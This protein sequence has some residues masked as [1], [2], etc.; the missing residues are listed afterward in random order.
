MFQKPAFGANTSFGAST[1]SPFGGFK[2]TTGTSAFGAAPAFGAGATSQPAAGGG[3]FGATNTTGGLFGNTSTTAPTSAFGTN[4]TG[5]FGFGQPSTSGGLFG[6]NTNTGGLFGTNQQN[7]AN[8]FG[9]KPAG[10]GFGGAPAAGTTASGLFGAPAQ[11]TSGLFA[12][13]NTSM[14]GGG[15][16]GGTTSAFGQPQTTGTAL[17]KYN[18]VPGTDVMMKSGAST[19]INI[20]H[21]CITCMKEY[22]NKSLEELRLEDYIA[23]RKG[24]SNTGMFGGF[25]PQTENKSL[26]GGSSFGQPTATSASSMFT[27]G[28]NTFGQSNSFSFGGAAQT[29]ATSTLFGAAKP[30]FGTTSAPGGGLF[31]TSTTQAAPAFGATNAFGFGANTQNQTNLFGAK[32]ATSAF[33]T[34]PASGT[35]GFGAFGANTTGGTLFNAKPA[36]TQATTFGA[37][38]TGFGGL[39][40]FGAATSTTG[41]LFGANN[42]F[43]AKPAAPAFGFGTNTNT[44]GFG[45]AS[46][47]NSFQK[48]TGTLF[49]TTFSTANTSL[50]NPAQNTQPL[51]FGTGT[52]GLGAG[53]LNFGTSSLGGP[54]LGGLGGFGATANTTLNASNLA[55]SAASGNVHE[56]ILTLAARPYGESSLYKDLLPDSTTKTEN[57]L[58]P[59]NPAAVKAVLDSSGYRVGSP[60]TRIRVH[61]RTTDQNDK[62]SLFDGLEESD[63]SLEGK[64]TLKP[65][66]KRLVLRPHNRVNNVDERPLE[67]NRSFEEAV[68]SPQNGIEPV[69]STLASSN[70]AKGLVNSSERPNH[71]SFEDNARGINTDLESSSEKHSSWLGSSR[72]DSPRLY[73]DL[74]KE[75]SNIVSPTERRASWLTTKPLRKPLSVH[76]TDSVENSVRELRA[77]VHSNIDKE[78]DDLSVSEEENIAPVESSPH[79]SGVKLTRPG[80]Y[81]V[82]SLDEMLRYK[83][84]DGSI[85]V[86]Q[87]TIGRKNYGNVTFDGEVNVTGLNLDELVQ[88]LNKEIVVYPDD[89]VKPPFGQGLNLKATV[90]LDRVW[91][92][93]KTEKKY[94]TDPERLSKMDYES[95]LR[96]ACDKHDTKFVEYRPETGS[97]V[98]RVKHFSK[99]G[100]T[101]S[102][103]D[104]EQI[105]NV[106]RQLANQALQKA[107]PIAPALPV[108]Q[109]ASGPGLGGL[110]SLA[111]KDNN[112]MVMQQ[113]S[114][115]LFNGS[116][117]AYDMDVTDDVITEHSTLYPDVSRAFGVKS[118]TGELARLEHR[119][120]RHVQLM[121]ASLYADTEMDD[122]VSVSTGDQRVPS[123]RS[124]IAE[125]VLITPAVMN[126][127]IAEEMPSAV[128]TEEIQLR[129][130]IVRPHTNILRYHRKVPPLRHTIAGRLDASCIA[131]LAVSRARLSRVGF[132]P[133]RDIVYVTTHN[134]ITDLSSTSDLGGLD[135]YVRG[136]HN[137][138][139][140]EHV[141]ARVSLARCDQIGKMHELL[142]NMS[143]ALLDHSTYL[144]GDG[145]NSPQ[146]VVTDDPMRR[147]DLLKL[148]VNGSRLCANKNVGLFTVSGNYCLEIWKL[149]EALWE[150]DLKNNGV[151]GMNERSIVDRHCN[152]ID[153]LTAAVSNHTDKDLATPSQ[154]EDEDPCDLHSQSVWILLL[155]GRILEAC[156]TA[157]ANGDLNM[158]MLIAQAASDESFRALLS[159]QLRLWSESGALTV[160]S[161]HKIYI[162]RLLA[163]ESCPGDGL[164]SVDWLRAFNA[165]ARYLTPQVPTLDRIVSKYESFFCD[166]SSM[167]EEEVDLSFVQNDLETGM[168]YPV[169]DYCVGCNAVVEHKNT[170]RRIL[171]LR[172]ELIRARA[173]NSR[174]KLIPESYTPDPLDYSLSFL[175][176][177]WF[178]N[179]TEQSITG[180]A[181]QLEA[182]GFWDLAVLIVM[183][184][185][186]QNIRNNCIRKILSRNVPAQV[187]TAVENEQMKLLD[188]L[189]IPKHWILL[190]QAHRA[191]YEKLPAVEVE[192]LVGAG[193]WNAAHRVLVNELMP[194]A[195][196]S[197]KFDGLVNILERMNDA[198][199]RNEVS[200]WDKGGRAYYHYIHLRDELCN[201]VSPDTSR[202]SMA[203]ESLWPRLFAMCNALGA[204]T[205]S[206]TLQRAARAHVSAA[207]IQ[208]ANAANVTPGQLAALL[209]ALKLP[210]DCR[211]PTQ[212][213]I[214]SEL[215]A[216]ASEFYA[217]ST[218]SSPLSSLH[219]NLGSAK[220]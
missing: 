8:T 141:V 13:Q 9:A 109:P 190:A 104:E 197:N 191:K 21:H 35:T 147:L 218:N 81:T 88:F 24:A 54:S 140:S 214:T 83:S 68:Q 153:W 20:K 77:D 16:F 133:R 1:S 96:R 73:P 92:R 139:W 148:Y 34:T 208:L 3:L 36:T 213:K 10:F 158:A 182:H 33:G 42:A 82:P 122:D 216:R 80:Y 143:R 207:V 46:A 112:L 78:N 56:Q 189:R 14:G 170:K 152:L 117:K 28:T 11:N 98:F 195:V 105:G 108:M 65:S 15:L 40:G 206:S 194:R 192:H 72:L 29:S 171:D 100:L 201:I 136:R 27:G 193:Q 63:A 116:S 155:G 184:H 174:P 45:G 125:Q 51:S 79:P 173:T 198:A 107:A 164:A 159:Q 69:T 89:S 93:D 124:S 84:V 59:T 32:P 121:K 168:E 146:L 196:L 101:D 17:V 5:G 30:A 149:C 49:P 7:V 129:P 137:D 202:V 154:A 85:V 102:D 75:T 186:I 114:L 67:T 22:E 43:A 94:I 183:F 142:T 70:S 62:K 115:N 53:G 167:E 156:K 119:S 71:R 113:T 26:F 86:P 220:N 76:Q 91:P 44:G 180:M 118:P 123:P 12:S 151:P 176:G 111:T 39:G 175:L 99:Y 106:Q 134:A 66:R 50:F 212:Q 177:A 52:T 169:P 47:L 41:G 120:S 179:P 48:P 210:P 166:V 57:M 60:E 203:V 132:G 130:L 6:T 58:K 162:L 61:P 135:K 178:G 160:I 205:A 4:T 126:E 38:S 64:L 200:D 161:R 128:K 163:G 145:E 90:T 18:P 110:T 219:R 181:D 217:D 97:W 172:Y 2:S 103:E 55:G 150:G 95:K 31:G 204:S 209:K 157:K 23:G 138:D 144:G 131:D 185:P 19:S 187:G 74:E 127:S 87:L 188:E 165:T 25:Q 211:V 215:A 37:P 199:K